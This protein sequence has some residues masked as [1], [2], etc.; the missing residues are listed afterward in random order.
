MHGMSTAEDVVFTD[1]SPNLIF[2]DRALI[3]IYIYIYTY[4]RTNRMHYLLSIYFNN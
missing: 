4:N 3:Y 1:V 2:F